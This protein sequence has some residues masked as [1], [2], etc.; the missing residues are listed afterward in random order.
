MI[1]TLAAVVVGYWSYRLRIVATVRAHSLRLEAEKDAGVAAWD[2]FIKASR[3]TCMAECAVPFADKPQA[4][5]THLQN[6]Q[7]YEWFV[8]AALWS[9]WEDRE[10]N[11]CLA[12]KY[13]AEAK[14]WVAQG[15]AKSG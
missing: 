10:R 2:D 1:V 14:D 11:L 13:L 9:D 5:R 7:D 12:E 6:C 15:T 3:E 8:H 4:C